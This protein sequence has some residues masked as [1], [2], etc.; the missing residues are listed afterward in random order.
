MTLVSI[1][2]PNTPSKSIHHKEPKS[3]FQFISQSP[4]QISNGFPSQLESLK[5]LTMAGKTVY[6]LTPKVPLQ[7]LSY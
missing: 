3:S 2:A 4:E 6:D 1:L 7:F 5:N